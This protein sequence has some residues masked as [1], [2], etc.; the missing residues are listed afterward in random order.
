MG[1]YRREQLSVDTEI[2][3][4]RKYCRTTTFAWDLGYGNPPIA[5]ISNSRPWLYMSTSF[6]N[7]CIFNY[8]KYMNW[9]V[10]N[11]LK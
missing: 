2:C 9:F 6:T 8:C 3:V 5:P 10:I 7:I 1:Y 4:V 11:I